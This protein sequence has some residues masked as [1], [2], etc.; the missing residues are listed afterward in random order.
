MAYHETTLDSQQQLEV[1][2]LRQR[3]VEA[4]LPARPSTAEHLALQRIRPNPFQARPRAGGFE[5]L[6]RA[7]KAS[8]MTLSLRVRPAPGHTDVFQLIFGERWLRA[9]QSAGV[10]VVL[11]E[12]ATYTDEELLEIGLMENLKQRDLDPLEEAFALRTILNQSNYSLTALAERIGREPSHIAQRLALLG[13]PS[14]IHTFD[15]LDGKD[16]S[17]Q[18]REVFTSDA[19]PRRTVV[20][21]NEPASGRMFEDTHTAVSA[22]DPL[23]DTIEKDIATLRV[24][25][26]RWQGVC[27]KR[28]PARVLVFTYLDELIAAVKQLAR[29]RPRH[30]S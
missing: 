16:L 24:I 7:I 19:A 26:E 20:P 9:A 3:E 23:Y 14:D 22:P 18:R 5:E 2:L 4:L 25:M 27:T 12:V 13:L 6:T 15:N 1:E 17:M 21:Q 11:C 8:G 29:H 30:K 28:H 10:D